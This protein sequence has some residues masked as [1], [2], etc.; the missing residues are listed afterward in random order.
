MRATR[1]AAQRKRKRRCATSRTAASPPGSTGSANKRSS[2]RQNT[3]PTL[4]FTGMALRPGLVFAEG[5][6]SAFCLLTPSRRLHCLL[7]PPLPA[8]DAHPAR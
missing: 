6:G 2:A 5:V 3:S 7:S 1:R 8:G 4:L